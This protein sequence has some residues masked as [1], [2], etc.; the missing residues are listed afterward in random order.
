MNKQEIIKELHDEGYLWA[1]EGYS[2]NELEEFLHGV[3][4]AQSMDPCDLKK[5]INGT[6]DMIARG[7]SF[8]AATQAGF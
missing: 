5:Y 2:K 6:K 3:R 7:Y 4:A 1:N 8:D